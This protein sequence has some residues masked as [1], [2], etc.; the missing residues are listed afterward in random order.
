MSLHLF[1]KDVKIRKLWTS[2]V[3][4]TRDQWS[5]PSESSVICSAHCPEDAYE[6]GLLS[7]F[8]LKKLRRLKPDAVT[9]SIIKLH[10]DDTSAS[11]K[12]AKKSVRTAAEKLEKVRVSA[13]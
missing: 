1:P 11:E 6:E 4:L 12:T 8:Q 10:R 7:R 2:K 9:I 3:K 13:N 5:G